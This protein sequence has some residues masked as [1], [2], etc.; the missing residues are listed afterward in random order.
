MEGSKIY[1]IFIILICIAF[2]VVGIFNIL[3][4]GE[5]LK[6]DID[7]SLGVSRTSVQTLYWL[8]VVLVCF[9]G[10][11]F[12]YSII[13]FYMS[14][15]GKEKNEMSKNTLK[16]AQRHYSDA[17]SLGKNNIEATQ[18][19]AVL[20]AQQARK[21]GK[22][23]KESIKLGTKA[24]VKIGEVYGYPKGDSKVIAKFASENAIKNEISK[25][26]KV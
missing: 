10:I 24:G 22:T 14:R 17:I 25:Y 5:I 8:N 23:L 11:L 26:V 16:D 7:E 2:I 9:S 3:K 13:K 20:T 19:V 1:I 6:D 21:E 12:L 18:I 15:K 4:Y